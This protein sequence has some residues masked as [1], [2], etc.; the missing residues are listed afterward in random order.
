MK[1]LFLLVL[2]TLFLSNVAH[3]Q[4]TFVDNFD[5]PHWADGPDTVVPGINGWVTAGFNHQ[6]RQDGVISG[7]GFAGLPGVATQGFGDPDYGVPGG[8]LM[9]GHAARNI[10]A[11]LDGAKYLWQVDV[12]APGVA[13]ANAGAA[14]MV[15][16]TGSVLFPGGTTGDNVIPNQISFAV[17]SQQNTANDRFEWDSYGDGFQANFGHDTDPDIAGLG[18]FQMKLDGDNTTTIGAYRDLDDVTGA[19]VGDWITVATFDA[20]Q[21]FGF[22]AG[23]SRAG[24]IRVIGDT[25]LDNVCSGFGDCSPVSQDSPF[26]WN[27]DL[28]GPWELITNWEGKGPPDSNSST[29]VFGSAITAPRTVTLDSDRT[30]KTITFD[31]ANRHAISGTGGLTLAADS[32][33]A[34]LVVNQGDPE[35]QVPLTLASNADFTVTSGSLNLN[36]QID[37]NG[38]TL[39]TSGVVNINHS[40]VGGGTVVNAGALGTSSSASI[41]GNLTSTGSLIIHLGENQ[42]DSFHTS[43]S[44]NLSGMLDVVLE[45]G[46]EPTGLFT[47]F[48]ADSGLNIAGLV[49][50]PSDTATFTLGVIGNDLVLSATG[51]SG[52]YNGDSIVNAADYTIW[53]NNIGASSALLNDPLGGQIGQQ[54]YNQWKANFGA[55]TTGSPW[56]N[57]CRSRAGLPAAGGCGMRGTCGVASLDIPRRGRGDR[58]SFICQLELRVLYGRLLLS[59]RL[60]W[61]VRD[62][63]QR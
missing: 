14:I 45:P 62:I 35:V 43:G 7:L 32:G 15:G 24:A 33:N 42:T 63:P 5:T 37:L 11:E 27:R 41:G 59:G 44:A 48:T 12:N 58:G 3:S 61:W 57:E 4:P 2:T 40:T 10:T 16:D 34:S 53:R 6:V 47:V 20:S 28:T 8:A 25:V 49:L 13:T 55:T 17:V 36:N 39:N 38:N 52:D 31:S 56:S 1:I 29:V 9:Y 46:F 22:G 26:T 18:W 23:P 21:V 51:L 30:V 19:A 54:Q 50:D 60:V